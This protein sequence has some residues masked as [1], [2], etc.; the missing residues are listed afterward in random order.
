MEA[1]GSQSKEQVEK[2]AREAVEEARGILDA[3]EN[4]KF[5]GRKATYGDDRALTN[6]I[7]RNHR[8]TFQST[9]KSQIAIQMIQ[10]A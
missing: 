5:L 4:Q 6:M 10:N 8:V 7:L 9:A 2:M 1:K 3:W